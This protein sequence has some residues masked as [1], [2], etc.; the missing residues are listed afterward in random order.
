M[1]G[2][3]ERQVQNVL[4][5]RHGKCFALTADST[6]RAYPIN[7]LDFG[8]GAPDSQKRMECFLL[9]QADGGDIYYHFSDGAD[10]DLDETTVISA[11]G[12]LAFADAA[13]AKLADG[14]FAEAR[15]DR[16]KDK[17]LV[18]KGSGT[19]RGWPNS[20]EGLA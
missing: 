11:G 2:N 18:V 6:A 15:I 10:T 19:L 3:L 7:T 1:S 5:P 4:P 13:G 8:Q 17:Y 16:Q 20:H 14:G 9:L 12:T